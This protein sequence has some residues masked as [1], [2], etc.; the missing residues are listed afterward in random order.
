M[1]IKPGGKGKFKDGLMPDGSVQ[2]MYLPNGQP[3]GIKMILEERGLWPQNQL[4]RI[5][6]NCKKNS[7]VSDNCTFTPA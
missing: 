4:N 7:P 6:D 1:N 2:S 5:C 3:K